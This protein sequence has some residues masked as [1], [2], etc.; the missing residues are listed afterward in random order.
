MCR[1]WHFPE[2]LSLTHVKRELI[3]PHPEITGYPPAAISR[4]EIGKPHSDTPQA[5]AIWEQIP[6]ERMN[7]IPVIGINIHAPGTEGLENVWIGIVSGKRIDLD[8]IDDTLSI[9]SNS[10]AMEV[11]A[12][13]VAMLP[14]IEIDGNMSEEME[15]RVWEIRMPDLSP[16]KQLAVELDR[17]TFD[18]DT[19]LYH[20]NIQN[21]TENVSELAETLVQRDTYDIAQWLEDV[22]AD[23]AE[24]E[25][26]KRAQELLE[27]LAEYKPL[28]KVEEMEEQNYNMID[29]VLNNGAGGKEAQEQKRKIGGRVSLKQ[30]L[31]QK[32]TKIASQN[33]HE[34]RENNRS[35]QNTIRR[36]E[37]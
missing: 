8:I 11:I 7:G 16:A 20:D 34:R 32:K 2:T 9:K 1:L 26:T 15:A 3:R 27:K 23:G 4:F 13:L 35:E 29:N 36:Q 14:E 30:R 37:K 5:V 25:E 24:P 18:Y 22:I 21:M 10:Q 33:Q 28:A 31:E 12:E 17:F 6:T 19:D